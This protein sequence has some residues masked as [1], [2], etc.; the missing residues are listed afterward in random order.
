MHITIV[1][2]TFNRCG[3][4]RK[5]LESMAASEV[6]AEIGWE[7][8]V[9]DNNSSDDTRLVVEDFVSRYSGRFRYLFEPRAGKSNA[10]N[11]AIGAARG[12]VLAFADDDVTVDKQWLY[13]L[14]TPLLNGEWVGSGGRVI[15]RWDSAVPAWLDPKSWIVAGPLVQFDRG[16]QP[17]SL[18]ETVVGT[19][20]AFRAR[21]F[22]RYGRFRTDLG[23]HPGSEIRNEDSEF[24][25]RL[26]AAGECLYYEP[27]AVVYHPVPDNRLN[28]KYF[29]AWWFDKGRSDI[30]EA[31]SFVM[32]RWTIAGIPLVYVRRVMRWTIQAICTPDSRRRFIC[33]VCVSK[34][35]GEVAELRSIYATPGLRSGSSTSFISE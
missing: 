8:L 35:L 6:P 34:L 12:E 2:C 10:L 30:R 31:A 9:V 15:A 5:A 23:P 21:I 27:Q 1:V 25:R 13:N 24:I 20:M 26:L 3:L 28:K 18:R 16:Q 4:L 7:I 33:R 14:T 17:G 29:L 32:S 19:N 11:A 22:E